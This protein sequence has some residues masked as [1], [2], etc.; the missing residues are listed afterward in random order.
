LIVVDL[1]ARVSFSYVMNRMLIGT[2][3]DKRS[4]RPIRALYASL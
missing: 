2:T 1:D 4:I 3:G